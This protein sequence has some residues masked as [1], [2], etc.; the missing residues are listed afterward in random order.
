MIIDYFLKCL[1][2]SQ[3][4]CLN[5]SKINVEIKGNKLTLFKKN[6]YVVTVII[7]TNYKTLNNITD[8]FDLIINKLIEKSN[9]NK[10]I[11]IIANWYIFCEEIEEKGF[12]K[13]NTRENKNY[14]KMFNNLLL[15]DIIDGKIFFKPRYIGNTIISERMKFLFNELKRGYI[16]DEKTE[17]N[18]YKE[19]NQLFMILE[20]M[21]NEI[22]MYKYS[23]IIE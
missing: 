4:Y 7:Q 6:K 22:N 5:N 12:C 13:I 19:I 20:K 14:R 2:D 18:F 10:K 1:K 21:L 3:E 17:E 23:R 8:F 9:L 16:S 15:V 11:S